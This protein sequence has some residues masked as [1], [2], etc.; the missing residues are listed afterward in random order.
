MSFKLEDIYPSSISLESETNLSL[1]SHHQT[2]KRSN[3]I[4]D[5]G[6][7]NKQQFPIMQSNNTNNNSDSSIESNPWSSMDSSYSP[8]ETPLLPHERHAP[9]PVAVGLSLPH[10]SRLYQARRMAEPQSPDSSPDNLSDGSRTSSYDSNET[11]KM[12]LPPHKELFDSIE[13]TLLVSETMRNRRRRRNARNNRP[14]PNPLLLERVQLAQHASLLEPEVQYEQGLWFPS[15]GSNNTTTV[16]P[17]VDDNSHRHWGEFCASPELL[18]PVV[19]DQQEQEIRRSLQPL[20][21]M[22][23]LGDGNNESAELGQNACANNKTEADIIANLEE[24]DFPPAPTPPATEV[25]IQDEEEGKM[26][27]SESLVSFKDLNV[28]PPKAPTPAPILALKRRVSYACETATE[29]V[30][31][32]QVAA[33]TSSL[34]GSLFD[35]L[36]EKGF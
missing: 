24:G 9:Q 26:K 12:P 34:V 31:G 4:Q 32:S 14:R 10:S 5:N 19:D 25:Q 2:N 21:D 15:T 8:I 1:S 20:F 22:E 16:V 7:T 11:I 29:V 18:T 23:I 35:Y 17:T 30:K 33:K 36:I 6:L 3:N 28:P 13:S 27:K